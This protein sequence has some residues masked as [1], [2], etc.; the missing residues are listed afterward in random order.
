MDK[1]Q[2]SKL[3]VEQIR[4]QFYFLD[5]LEWAETLVSVTT[6]ISVFAGVDPAPEFVLRGT[7]RIEAD[8]VTVYQPVRLGVPGVIYRLV[9]SATTTTGRVISQDKVLA[10]LPD[11]GALT[12]PYITED[13]TTTLYP[14]D[15]VDSMQSVGSVSSAEVEQTILLTMSI[16]ELRGEGALMSASIA[17]TLIYAFTV[18]MK[19]VGSLSSAS[20]AQVVVHSV[21]PDEIKAVGSLTSGDTYNVVQASVTDEMK[22]VGSLTSGSSP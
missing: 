17:D 18:E 1:F 5:E 19:G 2:P 4:V 21:A 20:V 9:C 3:V 15:V 13:Y 12:P 7:A 11:R 14:I 10:I 8:N 22:A 6:E 16:D